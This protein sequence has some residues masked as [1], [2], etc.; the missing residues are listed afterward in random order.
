MPSLY[1]RIN[2]RR[3][4]CQSVGFARFARRHTSPNDPAN[5]EPNKDRANDNKNNGAAHLIMAICRFFNCRTSFISLG[6][7]SSLVCS[8]VSTSESGFASNAFSLEN[9]LLAMFDLVCKA[10][11]AAN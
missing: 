9:S 8:S 5:T 6:V 3:E 4:E 10:D 2:L 1:L 11:R 7:P